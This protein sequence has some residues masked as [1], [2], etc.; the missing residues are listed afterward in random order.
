MNARVLELLQRPE[1]IVKEDIEI[2]KNEISKFPYMQSIRT[3]HLAAVN[4][5]DG[6]NYAKELTKTAAFTTD[7]KILYQFINKKYFIE[8]K[9]EDQFKLKKIIFAKSD[10]EEIKSAEIEKVVQPTTSYNEIVKSEI[11][12]NNSQKSEDQSI[13]TEIGDTE[14]ETPILDKKE[15]EFEVFNELKKLESENTSSKT[16]V[17]DTELETPIVDKKEN[18]FDV[19][20]EIEPIT[21][22]EVIF[23][24]REQD[25][26][27]T[28]D[29]ILDFTENN[30]IQKEIKSADISFSGIDSFLPDVK[31][32]IPSTKKEEPKVEISE[33]KREEKSIENEMENNEV[34]FENVQDFEISKTEKI[35]DSEE[36]K[37]DISTSHHTTEEKS[38]VSVEIKAEENSL[39]AKQQE[40][41][42][43]ILDEEK[44]DVH[45]DWKP[46]NFVPNTLDALIEKQDTPKIVENK[47]ITP[48]NLES[49]LEKVEI[50]E[51]K[52]VDEVRPVFSVSFLGNDLA[53]IEDEKPEIAEE[54][55]RNEIITE[56]KS[57]VPNFVN[58]WQNWLK[59]DRNLPEKQEEISAPQSEKIMER[60]ADI[61]EKFIEEN[62]KISQ[63]KE[64]VNFVVKEKADD[65]SHLMTGTLAKLYLEQKLYSKAIKAYE[66]LQ[67]KHPEKSEE[68]ENKIKEVKELRQ[69]K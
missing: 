28:K 6:E 15:N 36:V 16:V 30:E 61:I 68:F 65:I 40:T 23:K 32:S 45:T 46:M 20:K 21:K 62:P 22:P 10:A 42:L 55:P 18:E 53:K 3:L 66:I 29:K 64:E 37:E 43:E 54:N 9:K 38:E 8:D 34:S 44:P 11:P 24:T 1:N 19:L 67:K 69:S 25:L 60:K 47:E 35:E 51:E 17:G 27:F 57:N 31:F 26:N 4:E 14:L 59:I 50:E 48:T 2:L 41:K 5:H 56:T 13:K 49:K 52:P 12:S 7:K 63:L 33:S 58:T 39:D